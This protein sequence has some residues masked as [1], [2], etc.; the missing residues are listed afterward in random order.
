MPR[1]QGRSSK[2]G[3]MVQLA[4]R[5]FLTGVAGAATLGVAAVALSGCTSDTP[6]SGGT[7]GGGGGATGGAGGGVTLPTFRVFEGVTPDLVG[8]NATGASDAFFSYP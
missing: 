3:I 4:R 1:Q 5:Q 7:S 6:G 8:D 2:G